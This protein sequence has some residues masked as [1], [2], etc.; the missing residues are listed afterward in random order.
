MKYGIG[1]RAGD[2]PHLSRAFK[3]VESHP[4]IQAALASGP[5]ASVSCAQWEGPTQDQDGLGA[6]E[7]HRASQLITMRTR[8]RKT[9]LPFFVSQKGLYACGRENERI[10][11]SQSP[12]QFARL[13]D[14]GTSTDSLLAAIETVGVRAMRGLGPMGPDGARLS[15]DGRFSDVEDDSTVDDEETL[16]DLA[17]E[18]QLLLAGAYESAPGDPIAPAT[19]RASLAVGVPVGLDLFVD[20][21]NF[22]SA[23]DA[24][25]TSAVT[26]INTKDTKGGWHALGIAEGIL[27]PDGT[28]DVIIVNSWGAGGTAAVIGPCP[29][30]RGH[31]R[32]KYEA[33]LACGAIGGISYWDISVGGAS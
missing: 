21:M 25:S 28:T 9:P 17:T 13:Q 11:L 24:G 30:P 19:I 31:L 33:L 22:E 23:W 26:F 6:C 16:T 2:F 4:E 29:N 27:C 20:T 5:N 10:V 32:L 18:S 12:S 14:A 7:A 1:K 3:D 8:A 15:T